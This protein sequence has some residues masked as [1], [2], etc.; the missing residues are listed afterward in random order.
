MPKLSYKERARLQREQEILRTAA[1]MIRDN[2]YGNLNMDELAEKVGISKPTLYQHFK[3]KD[4][5]VAKTMLQTMHEME[6]HMHELEG[7][8]LEKL[9]HVMRYMLD[10]HADPD[11]LSVAI[12]QD[13]ATTLKHL[14]N[15]SED[16]QVVQKRVGDM[17]YAWVDQ[18]KAAGDIR[19][20]MP[21]LVVLGA[22]FSSLSILRSPDV[23]RDHTTPTDDLIEQIV[24]FF[25]RGITP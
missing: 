19:A 15:G 12:V 3:G 8:A 5:M 9:E 17:L 18:A 21:S 1:R 2:G 10:A 14:T 13:T 4:D 16:M 7:T 6:A 24:T 23:M 22:M 11:G 20:D 25:L